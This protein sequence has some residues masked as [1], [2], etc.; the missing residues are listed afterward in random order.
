MCIERST[1]NGDQK[2]F[3]LV[4]KALILKETPSPPCTGCFQFF[5]VAFKVIFEMRFETCPVCKAIGRNALVYDFIF[6][7]VRRAK[8]R[9]EPLNNGKPGFI[10]LIADFQGGNEGAILRAR[11]IR[12]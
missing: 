5:T 9:Q 3:G 1:S 12:V 4:K 10:K 8:C 6:W 11:S 2:S 7:I